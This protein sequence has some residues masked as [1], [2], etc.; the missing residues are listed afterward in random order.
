ML[1]KAVAIYEVQQSLFNGISR[2]SEWENNRTESRKQKAK[3]RKQSEQ[4]LGFT[5]NYLRQT[6]RVIESRDGNG[7]DGMIGIN[8]RIG[9]QTGIL[10]SSTQLGF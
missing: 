6:I 9:D 3:S 1:Q 4:S 2:M 8:W 10:V 7:G 5:S